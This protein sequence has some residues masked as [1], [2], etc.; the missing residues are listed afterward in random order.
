[1]LMLTRSGVVL[2]KHAAGCACCADDAGL[3]LGPAVCELERVVLEMRMRFGEVC[4]ALDGT[5]GP[6]M[7][8]L[9]GQQSL[10][11]CGADLEPRSCKRLIDAWRLVFCFCV[12]FGW[13][14]ATTDTVTILLGEPMGCNAASAVNDDDC[15]VL[16]DGRSCL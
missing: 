14:G 6:Y 1:V 11:S 13:N 16:F 12:M 5:E 7:R 8:F 15:G 10:L 9:S 3:G 2:G 4:L